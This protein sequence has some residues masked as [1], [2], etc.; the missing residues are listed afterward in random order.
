MNLSFR[1]NS[2]YV[3]VRDMQRAIEFYEKLLGQKVAE[4]DKTYSVFDINGFRYELFAI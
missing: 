2:M 4:K 3:C 1:I